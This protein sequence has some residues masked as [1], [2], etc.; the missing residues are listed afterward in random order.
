[1]VNKMKTIKRWLWV[2]LLLLCLFVGLW[3]AQDNAG[4]VTVVLLGFPLEG[5]SLGV[6]LLLALLVGVVLGM[7]ASLPLIA[8]Q[9]TRKRRAERQLALARQG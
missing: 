6:W 8:R 2:V 7:A 4:L 9:S 1:M 5:L 3:L